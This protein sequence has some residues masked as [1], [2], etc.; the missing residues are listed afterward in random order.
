MGKRNESALPH[1]YRRNV[2]NALHL[3]RCRRSMMARPGPP[4][5]LGEVGLIELD[6][7]DKEHSRTGERH[8]EVDAAADRRDCGHGPDEYGLGG[9]RQESTRREGGL[10]ATGAPR[11]ALAGWTLRR[12]HRQSSSRSQAPAPPYGE[13]T[14]QRDSRGRLDRT[15]S[16]RRGVSI[17]RHER[18][19]RPRDRRADPQGAADSAGSDRQAGAALLAAT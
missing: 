2:K 10:P 11:Q 15:L 18:P 14:R 7:R 3:Q 16:G 6:A 12:D 17:C 5:P 1:P 19:P 8:H 9:R 13:P 4:L